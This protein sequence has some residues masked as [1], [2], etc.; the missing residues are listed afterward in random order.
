MTCR[1][2]T[3]DRLNPTHLE[4]NDV[5][6]NYSL[7]VVDS[8]STLAIL[9]STPESS[10][11]PYNALHDFQTYIRLFVEDYGDGTLGPSGQG[12]RARGFDLDSKVQVFE[13]TIRGLG[14][15]LSAHLFAVGELPIRGYDPVEEEQVNGQ[16]GILWHDGFIYDGQ[17]LRLAHDLGRRLLP[18][19]HTPTGLPYPRVNLRHGTPFYDNSPLNDDAEHGQ[20]Q[21]SKAKA[22]EKDI[23]ETCSAGASSLVLEFSVLSRLTGDERFERLGK[24]AFWAVWERRSPT[25]LIGAGLDAE[26]GAW[27]GPFTGIGAGID[28]FFE[29]AF[30]SHI[31][32][33]GSTYDAS[34]WHEDSPEAFLQVWKEAHAAVNRHIL[35]DD[36]RF[37]HAH[38]SQNDLWTGAPRLAW[39]DSLSAYYPGLLAFA[40]EL[41][42][43]TTAHLLYTAL[44]SRYGALPER[45]NS[46]TGAIDNGLRWWGGRPEFIESTW[47]LYRATLDPWYLHVGEMTLR[48]I[49]RRCWTKCGWAGLQDVR[50]GEKNDRMESFFL[51][52]TAKYLYLL[53]DP[54][55]PLNKADG[56][57]VFSTEGHPLVIPKSK[58]RGT[59]RADKK[60]KDNKDD[61]HNKH[62]KDNKDNDLD[63][64][65]L[66]L[67]SSSGTCPVAPQTLPLTVSATAAR[68][69]VFHAASLA[70]LHLLPTKEN[71][72]SGAPMLDYSHDHLSMALG[73]AA[74]PNNY[75]FYPWTLPRS[76][77]PPN[78]TSA[79]M[80]FSPTFDLTFPTLPSAP[81]EMG[82]L[83][84]IDGGILINSISGLRFSMI[85]EQ[86]ESAREG[87]EPSYRIFSLSTLALGRD[88]G[89]YLGPA[90][91]SQVTP[92]DPH[93]TRNRDTE[94]VDLIIDAPAPAPPFIPALTGSAAC[95]GNSAEAAPNTTKA[96]EP[97]EFF[98]LEFYLDFDPDV[99]IPPSALENNFHS[100]THMDPAEP[101]LLLSAEAIFAQLPPAIFA[102]TDRLAQQLDSL[103][104]I[105]PG[106]QGV[107]AALKDAAHKLRTG[108]HISAQSLSAS[109]HS[110]GHILDHQD[111]P[112]QRW[113]IPAT[114]PTGPGSAPI[115]AAMH[116]SGDPTTLPSG[117][118]P[119][120]SILIIDS[121]LCPVNSNPNAAP[122]NPLPAHLIKDYDIII[123]KRGGCSFSDKLTRFPTI[124]QG[125]RNGR[126]TASDKGL[127]LVIVVCFDDDSSAWTTGG[128]AGVGLARPLLQ[129]PQKSPMGIQRRHGISMV[130]VGGGQHV[131]DLFERAAT[132]VGNVMDG[133]VHVQVSRPGGGGRAGNTNREGEEETMNETGKT[134]E[135]LKERSKA[136]VGDGHA[137]Q[138]K[139]EK[140]GLAVKRRFYWT[141]NGIRINNLF[142]G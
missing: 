85:L 72:H 128:A 115:P 55:H 41:D 114:L 81:F 37:Q 13:T 95:D 77:I 64:S 1:P 32:F 56:A 84:K 131:W 7:S 62:N 52:E 113:I 75:T 82:A 139:D 50:T 70:R 134:G 107:D 3:R 15:L 49:S 78:A 79:R 29:Y 135:G 48:D 116:T 102:D 33:S 19:F 87:G 38:Y 99:T 35:R 104:G 61:K 132:A 106:V 28:S 26:T 42:E 20:C 127:K 90:T 137:G 110:G 140:P 5:L 138:A 69:D 27:I 130:L 22:R 68:P 136:K 53:F 12:K 88:E 59:R 36:H 51:S 105:M 65:L 34:R 25:N 111:E 98:D 133:D 11:D 125:S 141:S 121:D 83:Q 30:K 44:W 18:A 123:I 129:E 122:V 118:L 93:F 10:H 6:G 71:P 9:A 86:D 45:W 8:L 40:G 103:I 63:P 60:E 43:A 92:S 47:Y 94:V 89:L 80:A 39:I 142:M 54:D 124:P 97:F 46:Q 21:K 91:L 100:E 74:S 96:A 4:V 101:G 17:L 16:V 76:L 57:I 23:T 126:G 31:L 112:L 119:F 109:V 66:L 67:L 24:R 73:T 120:S 58:R 14:G 117:E 108:C 2:F